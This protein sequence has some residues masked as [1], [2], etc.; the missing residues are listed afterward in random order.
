MNRALAKSRLH[1][2][3]SALKD[4]DRA[5]LL[6]EKY[7]KVNIALQLIIYFVVILVIY[8]GIC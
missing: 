5:I 6:N 3:K 1:E 8:I 4:L 7:A 2:Y